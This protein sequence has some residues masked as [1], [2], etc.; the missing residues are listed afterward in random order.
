MPS[1]LEPGHVSSWQAPTIY[2]SNVI[3]FSG[4]D[5]HIDFQSGFTSLQSHQQWR[6]V[7]LSPHPY[8]HLLSVAFFDLSHSEWC[9]VES[10]SHFDLK[11]PD[12]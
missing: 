5:L 7:S 10:Q 1:R 12:N 8:Q 2:I 11:Y 9:E 4:D 6:S 3:P